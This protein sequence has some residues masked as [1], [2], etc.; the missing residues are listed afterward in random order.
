M[1]S[2]AEVA[3]VEYAAFTSR[4]KAEHVTARLIVRRVRRL[5]DDVA[6]G[7][8]ELFTAW[9]YHPVFT[10]NPFE[11]LQAEHQHRQH[12]TIKQVIAD[13]RSSA[14]ARLPPGMFQANAAW[15]T[16]W[17]IAH[18]VLRAA[19]ALA[20]ALHAKAATAT[21]RS[22][23]IHVPARLASRTPSRP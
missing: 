23:L 21:I 18:N 22:H 16:L 1:V 10:D 5:N 17:A 19:G 4:M 20:G 11:L 3:E 12:A 7:Q 15:V 2:D 13:G 9:R 8:G 14:P 6:A